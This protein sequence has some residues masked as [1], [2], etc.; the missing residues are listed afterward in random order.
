MALWSPIHVIHT[1][2][3]MPGGGG[4]RRMQNII[5]GG[6]VSSSSP[7]SLFFFFP[8]PLLLPHPPYIFIDPPAFRGA[9]ATPKIRPWLHSRR[10]K[11]FPCLF[12]QQRLDACQPQR[13]YQHRSTI[14]A[15]AQLLNAT[16]SYVV[17]KW[18]GANPSTQWPNATRTCPW[19]SATVA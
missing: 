9:G 18:W 19:Q 4:Q 6:L 5:K 2:P 17:G 1:P 12:E 16:V 11:R 10:G 13:R 15:A 3:V 8:P 7:L 14:S